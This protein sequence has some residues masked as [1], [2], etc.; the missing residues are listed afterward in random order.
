MDT[1]AQPQLQAKTQSPSVVIIAARARNGTIG[2]DNRIPWKLP[3]DMKFFR[4]TTRG[5]PVIMGRK[6]WESLPASFRPLPGRHNV[7]LSRAETPPDVPQGVDVARTLT[8]AVA[9]TSTRPGVESVFVIGGEN[10]YAEALSFADRVLLTEIDA[11]YEGDA[12]FPQLDASEWRETARKPGQ[13]S[14]APAYAFVTYERNGAPYSDA[15]E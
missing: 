8:E 3:E 1:S 7:V 13:D 2:I 14:D 4:D 6:T 9:L 10:V 5:K 12:F 15:R 11:D